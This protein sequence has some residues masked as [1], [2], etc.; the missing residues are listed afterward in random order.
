MPG[1]DELSPPVEIRNSALQLKQKAH[2]SARAFTAHFGVS[3]FLW[4]EPQERDAFV[5]FVAIDYLRKSQRGQQIEEGMKSDTLEPFV[6]RIPV[7]GG[8]FWKKV[9]QEAE[10][11]TRA[12]ELL[13]ADIDRLATDTQHPIKDI[14]VI[15]RIANGAT[16]INFLDGITQEEKEQRI[17]QYI[18]AQLPT[19]VDGLGKEELKA[20]ID[21]LRGSNFEI[22]P[23]TIHLKQ[24]SV[25]YG[26]IL[27][28]AK[29]LFLGEDHHNY[30]IPDHIEDHAPDFK[31]AGITHFAIEANA[32]EENN[33]VL[34]KLNKGEEVDRLPES[35]TAGTLT[36]Y[37]YEGQILAIA[38]QGIQIVAVD[39]LQFDD[40]ERREAFMANSLLKILQEPHA[41]V[42]FRVGLDH[43]N[44]IKEIKEGVPSV[45]SRLSNAGIPIKVVDFV[46][47]EVAVSS[48]ESR[49]ELLSE[50]IRNAGLARKEFMLDAK[51]NPD[52]PL[53][54]TGA[55]FY[56]H[57]PEE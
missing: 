26:R 38:K 57:L 52:L 7:F 42:A 23:E 30:A 33:A 35:L 37:I 41:R 32:E 9:V 27:G 16:T 13:K 19:V 40:P 2:E 31:K 20:T 53:E 18:K 51:D 4:L 10:D 44:R 50:N 46:G 47:G 34:E 56:I 15:Q 14:S 54:V 5:D 21:K 43:A 49:F 3:N 55:D 11:N 22:N 1:E 6:K 29:V 12:M 39:E 48:D 45:A 25:D 17:K 24:L 8:M 28:N 36:P